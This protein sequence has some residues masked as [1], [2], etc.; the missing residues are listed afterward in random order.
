MVRNAKRFATALALA[1]LAAQIGLDVA[2]EQSQPGA[3]PAPAVSAPPA[4]NKRDAS[5][6]NS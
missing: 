4:A 6:A 3:Y 1:G 5:S 2:A